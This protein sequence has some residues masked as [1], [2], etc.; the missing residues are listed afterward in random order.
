[1]SVATSTGTH[2]L[3]SVADYLA[4]E[5]DATT[6]HEYLGGVVYAMAGASNRHNIVATNLIVALGS[7][8][9]GKPCRVYNS[10]TKVRI[11]TSTSTRFYYPDGMVVCKPNPPEDSFQD[12]P[13]VIAEVLSDATRRTDEGEKRDAYLTLPTLKVLLLIDP[14][15]PDVQIYRRTDHGF[16][17]QRTADAKGVLPLPDIDIELP[18]DELY[19][20]VAAI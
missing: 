15:T 5:A 13:A 16:I 1:M 9:R 18:L 8:L 11:Q 20:G 19:E 14:A 12:Q 6:K 4:A 10:D 7:R 17:T 3:V 2:G